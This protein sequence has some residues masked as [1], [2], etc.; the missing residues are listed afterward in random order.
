MIAVMFIV[1][2]ILTFLT[3]MIQTDS[4][5]TGLTSFMTQSLPSTTM[6]LWSSSITESS[7]LS[8][9]SGEATTTLTNSDL[10]QRRE[11]QLGAWNALS[12]KDSSVVFSL[13]SSPLVIPLSAPQNPMSFNFT[14]LDVPRHFMAILEIQLSI[15]L[16]DS[17]VIPDFLRIEGTFY[18]SYQLDPISWKDVVLLSME[19]SRL[20][21]QQ[22]FVSLPTTSDEI[23]NSRVIIP[24]TYRMDTSLT[25]SVDRV[26]LKSLNGT[27]YL[28]RVAVAFYPDS[29]LLTE[30]D[31]STATGD[32]GRLTDT[33]RD[34]SISLSFP[35]NVT[36]NLLPLLS[37]TELLE[38]AQVDLPS[39]ELEMPVVLPVTQN[40]LR[41]VDYFNVTFTGTSTLFFETL[42]SVKEGGT[43]QG[44]VLS[45][46]SPRIETRKTGS[47]PRFFDPSSGLSSSQQGRTR[48]DI[49]FG[50]VS[51]FT[52]S[53][54]VPK[55]VFQFLF[56]QQE[57]EHVEPSS[58]LL[59]AFS[60]HVILDGM[61]LQLPS[62]ADTG[63][64]LSIS[65]L[66]L[67]LSRLSITFTV[68]AT[69]LLGRL[70]DPDVLPYWVLFV[71]TFLGMLMAII[72]KVVTYH[73]EMSSFTRIKNII[74]RHVDEW[75]P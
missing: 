58:S 54:L 32:D 20:S 18:P 75:L 44:D 2:L 62:S 23:D 28:E 15:I 6:N 52:L 31:L 70:T 67:E 14:L 72:V 51:R 57:S 3:L 11:A 46:I 12:L 33:L 10:S 25:L 53:F 69:S 4:T 34:T 5:S 74:L 26:G 30:E 71:M 36:I 1:L 55:E 43:F 63:E 56:M 22:Y 19:G 64:K 66:M 16:N 39:H 37:N 50:G 8:V 9:I 60:L 7:F 68:G 48:L 42:E 35:F 61:R 59:S 17:T 13:L 29:M 21:S 24:N 27:W 73:H 45:W 47:S 38:G 65:M 41:Y 40:L 49:P